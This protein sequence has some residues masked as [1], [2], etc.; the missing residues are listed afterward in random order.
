MRCWA[1]PPAAASRASASRACKVRRNVDSD[2]TTP[3][4][5]SASLVAWSASAGPFRDR[6]E[7]PGAG[8]H[9]AQ[10]QAQDSCQPVTH[11]PARPGIGHRGQHRQQPAALL[12]QAPGDGDQTG[13]SQGQ[14]GMMTQRAW[15][16]SSDPAGA[17]TAMI[18]SGTVP[19]PLPA[20]IGVSQTSQITIKPGLCRH[21]GGAP[22]R[23]S[24]QR[25]GELLTTLAC[26]G[27]YS[28]A[29]HNR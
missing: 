26:S 17:G 3:V 22:D 28:S 29:A 15:P 19:A 5:P 23:L 16:L 21:P 24:R 25:C 12:L 2:G 4:T 6:R 20:H 9:R 18:A 27:R 13:Q 14:S 7:R 11:T 1:Q 10:R 8:Q